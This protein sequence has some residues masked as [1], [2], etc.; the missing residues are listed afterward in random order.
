MSTYLVAFI[1]SDFAN[2]SKEDHSVFAKSSLIEEGRGDYALEIG[3]DTLSYLEEYTN[4]SYPIDKM[5]QVGLP[6]DWFP[7][8]AMENWGIVTYKYKRITKKTNKK[9]F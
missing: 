6:D 5:Y 2:V 4:V 8:G 7:S 9:A 1:V 3:V